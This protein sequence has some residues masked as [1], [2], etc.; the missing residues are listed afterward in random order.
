MVAERAETNAEPDL[1][2]IANALT[3]A[4]R[5]D[6]ATAAATATWTLLYVSQGSR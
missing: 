5:D 6:V 2:E 4:D 1:S 3:L